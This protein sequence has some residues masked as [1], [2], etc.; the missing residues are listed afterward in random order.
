MPHLKYS[1]K[2]KFLRAKKQKYVLFE[3]EF[4]IV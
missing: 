2:K 3:E 1:L 4:F